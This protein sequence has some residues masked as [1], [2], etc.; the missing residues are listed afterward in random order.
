ML[1]IA[2]YAKNREFTVRAPVSTGLRL[3]NAVA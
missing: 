2:K 1:R 3:K